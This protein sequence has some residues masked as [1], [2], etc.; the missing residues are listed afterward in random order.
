MSNVSLWILVHYAV[1]KQCSF[2]CEVE[3]FF[4]PLTEV[5]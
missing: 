5:E 3:G 2:V 1:T 4:K